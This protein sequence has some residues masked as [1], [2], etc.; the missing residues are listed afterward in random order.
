MAAHG[1][2]VRDRKRYADLLLQEDRRVDY[3]KSVPGIG[4]VNGK[5]VDENT[6][7]GTPGSLIPSTWGNS[8]TDE[9]LNVIEAGG[10]EPSELERDQLLEAIRAL[11]EKR[12]NDASALPIGSMV[13]FPKG[14]VPPGFLEADGSVRST[15]TYPD[16]AAYLGT[17]F[18]TGTEP[19]GHFRLPESRGEFLRGW[20]HGRGVDA[21]RAIGSYQLDAL[22]NIIGMFGGGEA[23]KTSGAFKDE[24]TFGSVQAGP[25]IRNFMSFD[26]SRVAR[27]STETRPRNLAVM[28]C[29]KAWSAPT[30]QGLIDIAGLALEVQK[31]KPI[32]IVGG[33]K[34]L[35]LSASGLSA[36]VNVSADQLIVGAGELV[37]SLSGINLSFN[38]LT[39]GANGIDTGV[40]AASTW[41]SV[42]VIWNGSTAAGLL[43]LSATAPTMPAGYTHK[44][45]VG[46][47]RTDG[48]TNKYPFSF[49]QVG[50]RVQYKVASGSNVLNM[51]IIISGV[52]G[53]M[54]TPL[55]VSASVT[56]FVPPTA[57]TIV[58]S[59]ING[60]VSGGNALVAPNSSYGAGGSVSNLVAIQAGG[61]SNAVMVVQGS[62]LMESM[63]IYYVGSSTGNAVA[64]SGWEDNL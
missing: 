26:A 48:T 14:V 64:C 24:G 41:Y 42:W 16:L 37:S 43:S 57:K 33:H 7:S 46:W 32:A 55:W 11:I 6:A 13:P 62:L 5:F 27:A 22:Q 8:L 61:G 49:S 44:A 36:M 52:Q 12:V 4:L 47:I 31:Q 18:N 60:G 51:P 1:L 35:V 10:L 34:N 29:I 28:W 53:N 23:S 17:T 54:A 50:R 38:G 40:L 30:S 21:D 39:K 19:A 59:A 20:D 56:A 58:V 3:P 25:N 9:L 63:N 45:R 15:A 2:F